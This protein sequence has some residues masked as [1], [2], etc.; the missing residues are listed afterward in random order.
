MGSILPDFKHDIFIS[1]R[2]H[3]NKYDGWVTEFVE[4]LNQE[5]NATLKDKLTIYFDKNPSEGLADNH[6]VDQSIREKIK[7]LIFIPIISQTYCDTASFAWKEEFK[8]FKSNSQADRFTRTIQLPNGNYTSRILPIKIHDIELTD[9]KLLESELDGTLRSIDFIYREAGVN[10]PL[11]PVDDEIQTQ[12]GKTLYRN[13]INKLAYAIKE[14]IQGIKALD[15]AA[16]ASVN[17]ITL[18]SSEHIAGAFS[19]S[20]PSA[21]KVKVLDQSGPSVYLAWTSSD[22]KEAR[23]EMAITLKKAGFNVL[24]TTDCPADDEAFKTKVAQDLSRSTCSLHM[25]GGEFGRRFEFDSEL[26]FPQF[27][28]L[29]AKKILESNGDDFNCFIWQLPDA[30]RDMKPDQ[31]NLITYIRNNITHNMMFSNS[32]GPMQ[33]VDDM[34]VVMKKEE[35]ELYDSKDT[36]IFFIYNQQDEAEAKIITDHLSTEYPVEIMN[37]LPDGEDKYREISTQQI[38]KSKLAVVYFKHAADWALPFTK[39]VWKTVGGASSPT[40][41]F[42]IG[43]DDPISNRARN[44][45]APKVVSTIVPNKDVPG[46]VKKVYIT[47]KDMS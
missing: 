11:R 25:L 16:P 32:L 10:R 42:L 35:Q 45:K 33:L 9:L 39:Q 6:V 41:L 14:I 29:E 12:Y 34:R 8:V 37:I 23:E 27:Q 22:L 18:S 30:A 19:S 3:D 31:K 4:K 40:P 17:P 43:E 44:F 28:F 21:S 38:P 15:K 46:E 5:L 7:S 13:Q 24:P 2:H 47:V 26:S 36:E 20:H 1:Y